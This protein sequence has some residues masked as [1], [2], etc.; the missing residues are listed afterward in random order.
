F[1]LLGI[2]WI[3]SSRLKLNKERHKIL[4]DEVH[5]LRDGGSMKDATAEA[6]TAFKELTGWDYKDCWGNNNVVGKTCNVNQTSEKM[7]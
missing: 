2:T 4:V 7:A 1:L 5:R 6:K 3:A